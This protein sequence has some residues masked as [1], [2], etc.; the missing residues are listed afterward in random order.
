MKKILL[1]LLAVVLVGAGCTQGTSGPAT[2]K[3]ERSQVVKSINQAD[4]FSG[5]EAECKD[6]FMRS[7]MSQTDFQLALDR[8]AGDPAAPLNFVVSL[9]TCDDKLV[10]EPELFQTSATNLKQLTRLLAEY[11]GAPV[12]EVSK[13]FIEYAVEFNDDSLAAVLDA[14]G[15]V[16]LHLHEDY[17]IPS[18]L[19]QDFQGVSRGQTIA[20]N[21]SP[22]V[23]RA[24]LIEY[25]DDVE[26]YIGRPVTGFSGGPWMPDKLEILSE[27]GIEY[28]LGY[29][30]TQTRLVPA[31]LLVVNPWRPAGLNS[32]DDIAA[33]DPDG[34]IIYLPPG[35]KPA[36]CREPD[37]LP[38]PFSY[39][40]FDY[41]TSVLNA[42]LA[43][44]D[45]DKVNVF[46]FVIHPW[47]FTGP[48][49]FALWQ[50]WLDR[51]LSPALADGRVRFATFDEVA[52][53]YEA[54]EKR[55][56]Y[57]GEGT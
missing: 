28:T 56:P 35:V 36:H 30:D 1:V 3:S 17:V 2:A 50:D 34:P 46:Y 29:K 23:W 4:Y 47:D 31:D 21:A 10:N 27:L 44:A 11:G 55:E 39:A 19:G 25:K 9:H 5:S 6:A 51:V 33:Y 15:G 20:E 49:D 26:A 53:S 41:L 48:E 13:K 45:P 43:A 8:A 18:Y 24:A 14:G 52:A 42:T 12:V 38:T 22:D 7:R 57:K 37:N 32:A 16:T 54:W 40:S